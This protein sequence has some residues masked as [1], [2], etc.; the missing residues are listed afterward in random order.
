MRTSQADCAGASAASSF[1]ALPPFLGAIVNRPP[2]RVL[3]EC[4]RAFT[5]NNTAQPHFDPNCAYQACQNLWSCNYNDAVA[6]RMEKLVEIQKEVVGQ[7]TT[8]RPALRQ[9]AA[10]PAAVATPAAAAACSVPLR[11]C[12]PSRLMTYAG[13]AR[14]RPAARSGAPSAVTPLGSGTKASPLPGW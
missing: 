13:R 11:R 5:R 1:A 6:R 4:E 3:I 8:F 7:D 10:P 2:L 14:V 9:V 12:P